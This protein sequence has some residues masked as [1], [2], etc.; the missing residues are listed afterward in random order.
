MPAT[1]TS[2]C[3]LIKY[4]QLM[5]RWPLAC[6]SYL[7]CVYI[8]GELPYRRSP[9]T[10]HSKN[11][12]KK[13]DSSP[14]KKIQQDFPSKTTVEP[15]F[16]LLSGDNARTAFPLYLALVEHGFR[17]QFAST[18]IELEILWQQQRY[19]LILLEVSDAGSVEAAVNAA[20]R[21][22]RQD[23]RQFVGYL[24]DPI[25]RT[26]GLAGDAIFPRDSEQLAKA[27]WLYLN[28]GA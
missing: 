19:P 11:R 12:K 20:M 4:I 14:V 6:R 24:A 17:V 5:A 28:E 16:I 22:K 25:L 7:Y 26:S 13:G 10:R 3:L 9:G 15:P 1:K 27:L 2:N 21:L 8:A 18:Y 23:T